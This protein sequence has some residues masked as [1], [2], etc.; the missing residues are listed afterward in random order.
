MKNKIKTLKSGDN[1]L[2]NIGK[3]FN[4]ILLD[5]QLYAILSNETNENTDISN[6]DVIKDIINEYNE[7]KVR[8]PLIDHLCL[9]FR[10]SLD[11][12]TYKNV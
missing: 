2:E 12:L 8:T 3:K 7:N 6:F 9:T 1:V 11:I 5:Q 4:L 10:E